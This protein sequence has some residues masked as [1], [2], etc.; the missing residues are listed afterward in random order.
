[1]KGVLNV[2]SQHKLSVCLWV[3]NFFLKELHINVIKK[4]KIY[5]INNLWKNIYIPEFKCAVPSK[6]VVN[7]AAEP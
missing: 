3:G 7:V 5:I 4:S 6:S 2:V 1:M